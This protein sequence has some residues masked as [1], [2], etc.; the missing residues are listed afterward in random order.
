MRADGSLNASLPW[1]VAALLVAY[2]PM[3]IVKPAW[4]TLLVLSCALLRLLTEQRRMRLAP[5]WIRTPIGVVCFIAVLQTYGGINGV[6]PGGALLSVM[7]ALKLLETRNRR[8]QFVLLFICLFL[9]LASFLNEQYLWSAVYLLAAF[10]LTLAAW[11]AVAREGAPKPNRWHAQQAG[12]ALLMAL[13]ILLAMWVLFPRV[14]GPFWAIPTETSSGNT[15]LSSTMSPGDLSKLSESSEVAFLA[16]FDA[17]PPPQALRY[18]RAIVM[19]R[20][21]GRSWSADEP[22][23]NSA[24]ADAAVEGRSDAVSYRVTMEPT[25]QRWLFALDMP[26][27]WKGKFI[28]RSKFQ[29]LERSRPIDERL[30]Y[31]AASYL[32][33]EASPRL[34]RRAAA[35]YTRIPDDGNERARSMAL[36]T[37]AR[38][39]SPEAMAEALLTFFRDEPFYYTLSPPQL[40]RNSVD[41]F[42]FSTRRGFCEHYA[43][44]FTYMM[45]AAGVPA[46]IVAGYQ[47]GEQNPL[48]DF[49]TVRQSDAHAWSEIWLEGRGWVRVDPTAAVA[50]QRI[51]QN[52]DS[53]LREFGERLPGTFDLAV[54]ERLQLTWDVIN[55]RWNE[56]VLGFGPETQ[57]DLFEWLG[58]EDPDWVDLTT[59]LAISLV[60]IMAAIAGVLWWQQRPPRRDAPSRHFHN[61]Q[62]RLGIPARLGESPLAWSQRAAAL[63]PDDAGRIDTIVQLY[64]Q[65]RYAGN[66]RA[67]NRLRMLVP[68]IARRKPADARSPSGANSA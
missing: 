5:G 32:V 38:S 30:K 2:A 16:R 66:E 35:L 59:M 48:G 49:M 41:E 26:G 18:W 19:H 1:T 23:Y 3:A 43:S 53:A 27:E 63:F 8:D 4:I 67:V 31:S 9:I 55:A 58:L 6:G 36:E 25:N 52:L 28:Y 37:M 29:T 47:G 60:V 46:R 22:D 40:G 65:A 44:A 10:A 34:S 57:R 62:R 17:T 20:F 51:E 7:A 45:R 13:P 15:G 64:L 11:S 33:Y 54:L 61:L 39:G 21:D 24:N 12:K 50:P 68:G 42:V 14:P 56:W